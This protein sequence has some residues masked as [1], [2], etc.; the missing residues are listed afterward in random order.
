MSHVPLLGHQPDVIAEA[1][2]FAVAIG[3]LIPGATEG[4]EEKVSVGQRGTELND[5]TGR[6]GLVA[7]LGCLVLGVGV[8]GCDL[9]TKEVEHPVEQE[10]AAF[11][12]VAGGRIIV[13]EIRECIAGIVDGVDP[14]SSE[15]HTGLK[16]PCVGL[17]VGYASAVARDVGIRLRLI[18]NAHGVVIQKP[19]GLTIGITGQ[20]LLGLG[21]NLTNGGQSLVAGIRKVGV[22]ALSVVQPVGLDS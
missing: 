4:V 21:I 1:L 14:G 10:T 11:H 5:L 22:A 8:F 18:S 6:Q 15:A 12:H 17:A 20:T 3:R 2:S 13:H 9:F 16:F 19:G 7:P